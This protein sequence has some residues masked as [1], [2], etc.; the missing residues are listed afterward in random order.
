MPVLLELDHMTIRFGG[1]IAVSELNMQVEE[2]KIG[3]LIGPN[4]AGKSTVFNVITGIYTP[5]RGKVT[6]KGQNITGLKPYAITSLGI[7]RTFQ[8]IRLFKNLSVLDNVKIGRHCRAG[9]GIFG[10]LTRHPGI[11]REE[12]TIAEKSLSALDLVGLTAK[13]NEQARNLSYGEQRRL[14]IARALAAEP[15]LL[16]LDEPAAGMNP[17]EKQTLMQMILNIRQTGVT[18]LLVEHDMKF[19]MNISD[20]VDVLDYGCKIASGTPSEVQKDPA[21]ITAYLGKEVG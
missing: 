6:F 9:G 18:I 21:V 13:K 12:K 19:V 2:G 14:E 16:L 8:N 3:S 1:L 15:V 7:A 5:T 17:Q 4:G 10:A 11:K 20:C